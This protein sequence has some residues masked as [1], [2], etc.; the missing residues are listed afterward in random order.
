MK[1]LVKAWFR[2]LTSLSLRAEQRHEKQARADTRATGATDR[3][4]QK[5]RT[6]KDKSGGQQRKRSRGP[7]RGVGDG[8]GG[9]K[10][11]AKEEVFF[12]FCAGSRL[13]EKDRKD[14]S[15]G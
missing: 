3:R 11:S 14:L 8:G 1:F 13:C 5:E 10:G 2:G 4:A 7:G 12:F 6:G 15:E 9:R